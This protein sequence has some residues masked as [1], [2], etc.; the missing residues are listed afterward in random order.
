[1]EPM[2]IPRRIHEAA[3]FLEADYWSQKRAI[4]EAG[5]R[6]LKAKSLN[7]LDEWNYWGHVAAYLS[8]KDGGIPIEIID[9][10]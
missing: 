8:I 4:K 2:T 7:L 3:L 9:A 6:S 1:M 10:D 5:R